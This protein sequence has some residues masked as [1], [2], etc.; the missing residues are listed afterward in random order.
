MIRRIKI[1][2]FQSHTD[3]EI[4]LGGGLNVVT[5][6]TDSGKSAILRAIKWV[7]LGEP[8]GDSFVNKAVGFAEVSIDTDFGSVA[9]RRKGNKTVYEVT[10][11]DKT[12]IY[13]KAEVPADVQEI[14]GIKESTFGDFKNVLNFAYQL[15]APFLLSES[16]SAGAK[17]LGKIANA[18]VCDLAMKES[19]KQ[20]HALQSAQKQWKTEQTE[21]ITALQDYLH[22]DTV[23]QT[24]DECRKLMDSI[25]E[26]GKLQEQLE[27]LDKDEKH[28]SMI[29]QAAAGTLA[30]YKN[31]EVIRS[32]VNDLGVRE[33]DISELR[34]LH[35]L[36]VIASA[37]VGMAQASVERLSQVETAVKV[38]K[39]L[40]QI[41]CKLETLR[42]VSSDYDG[43]AGIVD[44]TGVV[45][46]SCNTIISRKPQI[47]DV[48][49]TAEKLTALRNVFS[50][51]TTARNAQ[52]A[53]QATISALHEQVIAHDKIDALRDAQSF[54]GR[55]TDALNK[56][57][58][59]ASLVRITAVAIDTK[60]NALTE[61]RNAYTELWKELDV[62]PLCKRPMTE[63]AKGGTHDSN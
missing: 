39:E 60:S 61:S 55:L 56:Y 1:T 22:L 48:K 62:C 42:R 9:K 57:N 19:A 37:N 6:A 58:R 11:N 12:F 41:D 4:N 53:L 5:G 51:Y 23:K 30:K 20:T 52:E 33:K 54:V 3:T 29:R 44:D 2:G 18:E 63:H 24:L 27:A 17:V 34:R 35:N 31:I 25:A 47:V 21:K 40:Q 36:G 7:A 50:T 45:V 14:L 32:I 8:N 49:R 43:V 26:R 15:D 13:E 38:M 46:M 59:A 28:R 10:K 16:P